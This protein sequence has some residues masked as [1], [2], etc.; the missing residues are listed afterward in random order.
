DR[1]RRGPR[2]GRAGRRR[3]HG[4]DARGHRARAHDDPRARPVLRGPRARQEHPE[5]LHDV[6]RRARGGHRHVGA[7]GLLDRLR[8]GQR[9]HRRARSRVPARRRLRAPRGDDDPAPAVHGVP[10]DVL[11]R[12]RRARVGRGGGADALRSLSHL[13]GAVV[14]ARLRGAGAL[15]LRRRLAPVARDARLR[16][17]S[18]GRDGLRVL[19]AGGGA[20]RRRPQGLRAPGP[21][22]PQRRLRPARGRPAVVRLV[23]VQRRQR[24][25]DR[26]CRGARLHQHAPVPGRDSVCLVR[27]RP[28]PRPAGHGDR[29]GDGDHRRLRGDN[30]GGRLRQPGLGAPARCDRRD[31]E[32]RDHRVASAHASGRD[33]RRARGARR[34]GH[35]RHPLRGLLRTGAVERRRRRSALRQRGSARLAGARRGGDAA[36]RVRGHVSAPAGDWPAHAASG[37][38]ARGGARDGRRAARR[39]GLCHGRRCDPDHARGRGQGPGA[40]GRSGL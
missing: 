28:D 23:R 13:C 18:G 15:G 8:R 24:L 37:D 31:S 9:D 35:D 1:P 21:P 19:R 16:R 4:V 6:R 22:P 32:L 34:R 36:L 10:G 20:G 7:R 17:R 11:H 3:R 2:G 38:R 30:P 5:H 26:Q 14:G 27:A 12:H 29:R 40:G 33:A 39:G 25:L